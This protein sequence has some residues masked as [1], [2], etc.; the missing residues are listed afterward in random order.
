MGSGG[1]S[2]STMQPTC[3]QCRRYV[4]RTRGN[5]TS[6]NG[7]TISSKRYRNAIASPLRL[8]GGQRFIGHRTNT[9]SSPANDTLT[10]SATGDFILR[11]SSQLLH[12][13]PLNLKSRDLVA[14][15]PCS[16]MPAIRTVCKVDL[17]QPAA[18]Q[19]QLHVRRDPL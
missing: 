11:I 10:P 17:D 16:T 14:A 12:H 9:G 19:P 3:N 6:S 2:L 8:N 13:Q 7:N 18:D 1:E 15:Y 4:R 5:T